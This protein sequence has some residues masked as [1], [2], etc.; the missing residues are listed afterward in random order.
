MLLEATDMSRMVKREPERTKLFT[1]AP[2]AL[3]SGR[4]P[5]SSPAS[6][7]AGAGLCEV[8]PTSADGRHMG[9]AA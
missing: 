8:G 5:A 4:Q 7:S 3:C 9:G 1:I 2:R 6:R